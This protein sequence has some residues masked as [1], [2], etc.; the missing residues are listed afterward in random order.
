MMRRHIGLATS[1]G[2]TQASS[3]TTLLLVGVRGWII[4]SARTHW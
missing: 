2:D 3:I 4:R 1:K